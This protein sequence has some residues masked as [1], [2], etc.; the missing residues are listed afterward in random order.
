[1]SDREPLPSERIDAEVQAALSQPVPRPP[2]W[3][4]VVLWLRSRLS[5]LRSRAGTMGG[6][7]GGVTMR[8]PDHDDD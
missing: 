2:W 4:R 3:R 7:W 8:D 1:M 5:G 6:Y